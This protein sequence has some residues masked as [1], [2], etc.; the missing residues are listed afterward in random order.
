MLTRVCPVDL[1]P[2]KSINEKLI[3]WRNET[4][5]TIALSAPTR[6]AVTL[7]VHVRTASNYLQDFRHQLSVRPDARRYPL[8]PSL[9]SSTSPTDYSNH[10]I[11]RVD[12]RAR[13]SPHAYYDASALW[14]F[15]SSTRA[16]STPYP[17]GNYLLNKHAWYPCEP[18]V[19][20]CVLYHRNCGPISDLKK[21]TPFDLLIN[22]AVKVNIATYTSP[23][24][25]L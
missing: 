10:A 2:A 11:S 5:L 6:T 15:F 8:V 17:T 12:E 13:A 25:I 7:S 9:V 4:R 14:R 18:P 22:L 3:G 23:I 1:D 20:N 21:N 16:R 19:I 24:L